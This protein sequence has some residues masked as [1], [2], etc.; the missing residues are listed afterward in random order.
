VGLVPT[1]GALHAGH[2]SLIKAARAETDFVVVSVFVNP[3]QFGPTEDLEAYPRSLAEDCR[4]A[5]TLGADVAFAPSVEELYPHGEGVW[6]EITGRLTGILCGRARPTHFRGV[7]TVVTKLF[8]LSGADKAY[9]GQKDGQQAQV[10][11]RISEDLFMPVQIRIMPIV[12]EDD[13]LALSSRN[14]YLSPEQRRAA[15]ILARS[16]SAARAAIEDGETDPEAVKALLANNIAAEPLASLEYA[17]I[18]AFPSLD[19]PGGRLSGEV[20]LALAVRIGRTR[21]IDNIVVKAGG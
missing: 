18:Y 4:L 9:F 7:A 1:M 10:I 21:L 12:R 2:A 13:G 15:L 19:E 8:N 20:F 17:E 14:A 3:T 6:V 11:T 16:L 5:E